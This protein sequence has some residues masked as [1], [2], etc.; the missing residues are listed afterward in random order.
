MTSAAPDHHQ[1]WRDSLAGKKPPIAEGAP[2]H[3]FYF[4]REG[5]ARQPVQIYAGGDR[6][7]A[8]IGPKGK[9]RVVDAATI[10]LR[11]ASNAVPHEAWKTVYNGGPWP[12]E[13]PA[14]AEPV[15]DLPPEERTRLE[16]D[17]AAIVKDWRSTQAPPPAGDN[18]PYD[19]VL[20]DLGDEL[21][22]LAE[23]AAALLRR[24]VFT[25]ADADRFANLKDKGRDLKKRLDAAYAVEWEPLNNA[26]KA[27]RAKYQP[28]QDRAEAIVK[29]LLDAVGR[30]MAAEDA[31]RRA[32]AQAKIAAGAPPE[33]V[34]VAP[35]HV[36]GAAGRKTALRKAA[37]TAEVTDWGA[38]FAALVN[39]PDM[40]ALAQKIANKAASVGAPF[41]GTKI[42]K[43]GK[44]AT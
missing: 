32:E 22:N 39:N 12:D 3:G 13:K 31:R 2:H 43:G 42:L 15:R 18:R 38:L 16:A 33:E 19:G 7:I 28:A 5:A 23:E 25:Q 34:K 17:A 36:G 11:V 35:V 9:G 37:D 24:G 40:Q 14:V 41:A 10:W 8:Y 21:D 26:I 6:L 29:K 4:L 44:K 20:S 1:F 27:V 30:W